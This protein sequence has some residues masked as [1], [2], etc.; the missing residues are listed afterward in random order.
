M[1]QTSDS[2]GGFSPR[3]PDTY[4]TGVVV[5]R[6]TTTTSG[7]TIYDRT[8]GAGFPVPPTTRGGVQGFLPPPAL[9]SMGQLFISMM[10]SDSALCSSTTSS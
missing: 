2:P 5:A 4:G 10:K 9:V 6:A 3:R 7:L 8:G 1:T